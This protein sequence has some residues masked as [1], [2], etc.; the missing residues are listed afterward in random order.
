[1]RA[2][3]RHSSEPID[4]PAP[5]TS[6]TSP[7][8]YPAIDGEIDLDRLAPEQVLDLDRSDL[9]REVEV[10]GDE[11]VEARERVHRD[12]LLARDLHDPFANVTG[13]GRDRDE[14]LV[15][16]PVAEELAELRGRPEDA[17][18][19]QAQVLL[20]RVV[21]DEAD[22]RVA[23][24]RVPEHLAE[25]QLRRVARPHD[26]DLLASR[27]D[28][29]C[30]RSL[31]ER[32]REQPHA[33]D[34]REQEQEVDDPD[35]ARDL[36]R[37]EVEQ[38]EDEEGGDDGGRHTAQDAPHVL[39]RDVPPPAVVEAERDEHRDRDP[40]D[41]DHDVP[42]EVAVVVAGPR[43]AL[44]PDVPG[45]HPRGRD[46]RGVDRDLPEPVSVDGRAH[47]YAGTPTAARTA[48]TTRSCCSREMPP[49]IGSARLSAAARSVSGSE[50]A[51]T[52]R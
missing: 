39:R 26:Q 49:H 28:R 41:E 50:P 52:P 3:C 47:G 12:P 42:L 32:P 13:R 7:A 15:R 40:D 20:P 30:A 17:D 35:P 23:E 9:A 21:V 34:E 4:P 16:A 29:A 44:E 8:R 33:H 45:E 48:S 25:D 5:V 27:H 10:P 6:T 24:R 31:D 11:L 37:M 1:M 51:G 43:V 2:I 22:R 38:C 19:V 18:P 36:R 46:E 14:E